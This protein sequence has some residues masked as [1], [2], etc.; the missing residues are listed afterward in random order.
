MRWNSIPA[1]R[2]AI[3]QSAPAEKGA[4]SLRSRRRAAPDHGSQLFRKH[5]LQL[6]ECEGHCLL[7]FIDHCTHPEKFMGDALVEL[8]CRSDS[9]RLGMALMKV[10]RIS[11]GGRSR[12][13]R[14]GAAAQRPDGVCRS[15]T[16]TTATSR[17]RKRPGQKP[18]SCPG[19]QQD[20]DR[21]IFSAFS[22]AQFTGAQNRGWS[23][24]RSAERWWLM[25]KFD[26]IAISTNT[27]RGF[28]KIDESR[29]AGH[30]NQYSIAKNSSKT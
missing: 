21:L 19:G 26:A 22:T 5:A 30:A 17:K 2:S 24:S 12:Q 3:C 11:R 8:L 25:L 14:H 16:M 18:R 9:G 4:P 13:T 29:N 6:A 20:L 28:F 27:Y 10:G 7:R 23:A 1:D 15:S